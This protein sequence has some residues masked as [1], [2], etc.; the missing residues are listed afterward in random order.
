MNLLDGRLKRLEKQE[1]WDAPAT[2]V[3]FQGTEEEIEL[4]ERE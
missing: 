2:V 3:T 4:Q 1:L